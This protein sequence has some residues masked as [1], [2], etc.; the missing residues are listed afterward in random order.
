MDMVQKLKNKDF[1]VVE[2]LRFLN[3]MF[4]MAAIQNGKSSM[5][6]NGPLHVRMGNLLQPNN[7]FFIVLM[8]ISSNCTESKIIFQF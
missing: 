7:C 3:I 1:L 2:Y 4:G 6:C 8:L 5:G